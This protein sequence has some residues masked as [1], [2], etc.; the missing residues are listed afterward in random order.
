MG[1]IFVVIPCFN[2]AERLDGEAFIRFCSEDISR[3]ISFLFVNDGST[4]NTEER[5][6]ELVSRLPGRLY[7][8][9]LLHNQG[10][11]EAVRS[12]VLKAFQFK[13]QLVAY[14]D[15]DLATPLS[16]IPEFVAFF[17]HNHEVDMLLGARVH[18]LG[19]RICRGVQRDVRS[20]LFSTLIG[21][22]LD[23]PVY[24]SQCGAKMFRV[25]ERIKLVFSRPFLSRWIF[26]VEILARL[27]HLY[28]NDPSDPGQEY[29][30][31][32]EYP[33]PFW[34]DVGGS[35]IKMSDLWKGAWDLLYLYTKELRRLAP[36]PV[37]PDL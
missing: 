31:L 30:R 6:E 8:L 25:N 15:A 18:M 12:G 22:L 11:G 7:K 3:G 36:R 26:D 29:H 10:K 9:T 13:P 32:Y 19:R 33:L 27:L 24:D 23:L 20:R 34:R 16:V 17:A 28:R 4:D 21:L 14:W 1:E 5:L 2:E 35:H 37:E